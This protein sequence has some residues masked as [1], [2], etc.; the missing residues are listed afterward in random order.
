MA[1]HH[2]YRCETLKF[3]IVKISSLWPRFEPVTPIWITIVKVSL[4]LVKV[5]K[6]IPVTGRGGPYVCETSNLLHFLDSR[7]KD[8][9]EAASLK[10]RPHFTL[11]KIPGTHFCYRLSRPQDHSTVELGQLKNSMT[12]CGNEPATFKLVAQWIW[13]EWS[14]KLTKCNTQNSL[15]SRA[16][17]S[18]ICFRTISADYQGFSVQI[19]SVNGNSVPLSYREVFRQLT[20]RR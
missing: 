1:S 3:N 4:F 9:S 15:V 18:V 7:L 11:R 16:N 13:T 2:S 14:S 19:R 8:G 6:S 17:R 20:R 5:I 10:R 12:S